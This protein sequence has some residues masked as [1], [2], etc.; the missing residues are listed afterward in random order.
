MFKTLR[1][2]VFALLPSPLKVL[3]LRRRGH[4]I[5]KNVRIGIVY[6]DVRKLVLEDGVRIASFN[7]IKNLRELTMRA[8][9]RIGGWG[10]WITATRFNDEGNDG[11]GRFIIGRGSNITSRHF[12]DVQETIEIGEQTLVAGFHSAF[13]THTYTPDFRNVNRGI[14][15]GDHC[16]IGSHSIF[17]PGSGVGSCTFVG[18]GSVV[19]KDFSLQPFVMVGGNPAMVRKH[20]N[21]DLPFFVEDHGSFMPTTRVE[22]LRIASS[23]TAHSA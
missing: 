4:S 6:L 3:I 12:F 21:A 23:R 15:L 20:Y 13:F 9:A 1:L 16:Y 7:Y 8:G 11:F 17:T 22:R 14:Q 5:G 2:F 18:A 19:V 10:N